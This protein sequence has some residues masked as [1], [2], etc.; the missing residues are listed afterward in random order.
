[1]SSLWET[2]WFLGAES[3]ADAETTD[4]I[5]YVPLS[6]QLMVLTSY[7][8]PLAIIKQAV[9]KM[10]IYCCSENDGSRYVGT[11][12]E[13]QHSRECV[14]EA[15]TVMKAGCP[16]AWRAL[17]YTKQS[18]DNISLHVQPKVECHGGGAVRGAVCATSCSPNHRQVWDE[19]V[20]TERKR[21]ATETDVVL[22]PL[23]GV[24]K[25]Q[26]PTSA[27]KKHRIF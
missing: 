27:K 19:S 16:N 5:A 24:W 11:L 10:R 17:K 21:P 22:I 20:V 15:Q 7:H 1:M 26:R 23:N 3:T 2:L 6:G 14:K 18:S 25:P 12:E 13:M 8:P 9:I 4:L